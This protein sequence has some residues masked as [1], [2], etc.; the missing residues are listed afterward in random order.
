[1]FRS[2]IPFALCFA[3]LVAA[4]DQPIPQFRLAPIAT[5][6]DEP[7]GLFDDGTGR[8]FVI[9][10]KGVI[11]IVENGQVDQAPFLD[12]HDEVTH[13]PQENECGLLGLAFDPDFKTHHRYYVDYI[14]R[15]AGKLQTCVAEFTADASNSHTDRATEKDLLAFDQP[16]TNHK[17]GCLMFGP[18]HMLYIG[19]GDG[20]K[21]QDPF[22]Y[23]QNLG[24]YFSKI[25]RIDVEHGNPYAVPSDNPFVGKPGVIPETWCYGMR[26][27]WRFSFDRKTGQLWCGDVGQDLWEEIDL[28]EKGKDYGWSIREGKHPYNRPYGIET[29]TVPLT[30]P[31][32]DYNHSEGKCIIGGYV[33]RGSAIPALQ[34]I[35]VYGDYNLGWIAGLGWDGQKITFD[36]H[37]MQ[38]PLNISSFGEDKDGELYI[39]DRERGAVFELAP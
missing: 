32:K 25:L 2:L 29:T 35:Y 8:L 9:E 15:K 27:P 17:G 19:V 30:D 26:N 4:A 36:H 37:M 31:I 38:T 21:E 1:M 28:I 10:Q 39:C 20:G 16:F 5:G 34:G 23:G 22:G 7:I 14:T 18:D 12:I 13:K 6:L 11:V 33:Y 24:V 3:P